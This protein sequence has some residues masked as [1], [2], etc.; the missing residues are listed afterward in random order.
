MTSTSLDLDTPRFRSGVAARMA[1]MPTPTLR[2]WE[3]RYNVVNPSRSAAGQR[4]YSRRDVQRLVLLKALS[5]CGHAIGAIAALGLSELEHIAQG[6][7]VAATTQPVDSIVAIG[8]G[9]A[10]PTSPARAQSLWQQ[11]SSSAA[12]NAG[13]MPRPVD[14]LLV[15]LRSLHVDAASDVLR[16][17]DRCAARNVLVAYSFGSRGAVE[18]LQGS[19]VQLHREI[20]PP[21]ETDTLLAAVLRSKVTGVADFATWRRSDRRYSDEQLASVA[22]TS[23]IVACECPRHVAEFIAQLSAF[24]DYSDSCASRSADDALLHRYLGDIANAARQSFEVALERLA[25]AEGLTLEPVAA[26]GRSTA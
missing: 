7:E 11:Y 13:A 25:E 23:P 5:E 24:E 3:R 26:S 8:S 12:A 2:I 15:R 9:W 17:A 19:S 21:A 1:R 20:G 22:R 6:A 4:L 14:V 18:R 10:Q 16:L